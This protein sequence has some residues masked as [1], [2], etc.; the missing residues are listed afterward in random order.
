MCDEPF[1]S[2]TLQVLHGVAQRISSHFSSGCLRARLSSYR[3]REAL[4][5]KSGKVSG[6][7]NEPSQRAARSLQIAHPLGSASRP[8]RATIYRG[9]IASTMC[10]APYPGCARSPLRPTSRPRE[11]LCRQTGAAN[12]AQR[13]RRQTRA[14]QG[15]A[16]GLAS[17]GGF[18]DAEA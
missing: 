13:S 7:G 6:G 8:K 16:V 9:Q 3:T 14:G 10:A 18:L 12:Q 17:A 5:R 15:Y 1:I 11:Q 4:R 2:D